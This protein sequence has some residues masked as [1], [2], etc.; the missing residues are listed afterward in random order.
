MIQL[1]LFG[2]QILFSIIIL[3]AFTKDLV[4]LSWIGKYLQITIRDTGV[5]NA[6][7]PAANPNSRPQE[8]KPHFSGDRKKSALYEAATKARKASGDDPKALLLAATQAAKRLDMNK[9]FVMKKMEKDADL[10]TQ[11]KYFIEK[12]KG[13]YKITSVTNSTYLMA[14]FIKA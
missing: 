7:G 1:C 6:A 9:W 3:K 11:L 13:Y 2:V 8:P 12:R 14:K 4:T 5:R 10:A